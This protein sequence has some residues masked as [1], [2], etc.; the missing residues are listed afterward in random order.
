LSPLLRTNSR[1]TVEGCTPTA[2]AIRACVNPAAQHRSIVA[3][4][5]NVNRFPATTTST[6]YKIVRINEP[7]N[8]RL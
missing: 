7:C 5:S 1:H 6:R 8:N 2:T 4:C 3:R